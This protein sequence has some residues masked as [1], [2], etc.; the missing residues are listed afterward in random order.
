MAYS[1]DGDVALV[2]GGG[3]EIGAAISKRL[4][5]EGAKIAVCDIDRDKAQQVAKVIADDGGMAVAIE[6]DVSD[7]TEAAAAVAQTVGRFGK[8][9][10]LV[11]LAA[12][13]TPNG[14]VE[15][16]TLENWKKEFDVNLTGAF[17]ACKYA[18]PEM[19]KAGGGS[20]INISSQLG[21]LGVAGRAPYCTTKAALHHFTRILALDHSCDNIRANT[22]SP[23]AVSTDRSSAGFGD[24]KEAAA[25]IHGPKHLLGRPA[26]VDEIAAAVAF[27]ASSDASFVT[28]ADLLVDGGYTAFK[29]IVDTARNVLI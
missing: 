7:Q 14:T 29:G 15:T 13:V 2:V 22:I 27:L 10:V 5:R 19:R 8:L 9:T 16:I 11:N 3:G 18:V 25:K 28:A 23:G 12:A 4:A 1:L 20:I 6:C 21:H 17:L 24:T 26:R